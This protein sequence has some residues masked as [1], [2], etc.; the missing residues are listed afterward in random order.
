[1]SEQLD[2]FDTRDYDA[3]AE[4]KAAWKSRMIPAEWVAPY[5]CMAG[6]A[7]TVVQGWKC[8]ACGKIEING[9]VLSI[10][11]GIDPDIPGREDLLDHCISMDLRGV[12]A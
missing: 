5:D 4:M 12:V 1:M 2:M 9:F 10:N 7:G 8:P 6:P 3:E 11:H